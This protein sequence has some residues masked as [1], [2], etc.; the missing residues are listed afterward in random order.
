M[1]DN[2][3]KVSAG[4]NYAADNYTDNERGINLLCDERKNDCDNGRKQ[5]KNRSIA[6]NGF[7]DLC[8]GSFNVGFEVGVGV[9][10]VRI[11][12]NICMSRIAVRKVVVDCVLALAE[13]EFS[14]VGRGCEQCLRR[15]RVSRALSKGNC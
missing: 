12:V 5:R 9:K 10:V 14:A 15:G 3:L 4:I 1:L 7:S 2:A 8:N 13:G 6:F 11:S